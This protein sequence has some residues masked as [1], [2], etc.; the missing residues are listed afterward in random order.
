MPRFRQKKNAIKTH[1]QAAK[2]VVAA[3]V[4]SGTLIVQFG[5]ISVKELDY[6]NVG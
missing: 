1:D 5:L 3:L 4:I 2:I 6:E